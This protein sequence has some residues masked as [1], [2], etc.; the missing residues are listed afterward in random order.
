MKFWSFCLG[1]FA[2]VVCLVLTCLGVVAIEEISA[3]R[4]YRELHL[5][6]PLHWQKVGVNELWVLSSRQR[7]NRFIG[8]VRRL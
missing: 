5:R 7:F 3:S 1:V 4:R 8:R 6:F 2:G